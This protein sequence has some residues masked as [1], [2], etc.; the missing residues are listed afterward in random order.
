MVHDHHPGLLLKIEVACKFESAVRHDED[1]CAILKFSGS[2]SCKYS[3]TN[4]FKSRIGYLYRLSRTELPVW[5]NEIY[6]A[7]FGWR[8]Y[9]KNFLF[10]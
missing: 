6:P 9:M 3:V 7:C 2:V 1:M 10:I 8:I 4:P 5:F